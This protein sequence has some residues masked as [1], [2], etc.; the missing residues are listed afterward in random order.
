MIKNTNIPYLKELYDRLLDHYH[1]IN[2]H[3]KADV[4]NDLDFS[5]IYENKSEKIPQKEGHGLKPTEK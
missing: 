1:P 5:K 2:P 3:E 4:E